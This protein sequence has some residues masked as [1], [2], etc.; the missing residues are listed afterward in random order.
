MTSP[1]KCQNMGSAQQGK[2]KAWTLIRRLAVQRIRSIQGSGA[3]H[4]PNQAQGTVRG[5]VRCLLVWL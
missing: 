4:I 5:A 2:E 1:L 3:M